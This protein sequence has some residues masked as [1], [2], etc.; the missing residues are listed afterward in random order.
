M[1][2]CIDCSKPLTGR[3][4]PPPVRC[5]SCA[6]KER[7]RRNGVEHYTRN[8]HRERVFIDTDVLARRVPRPWMR[9]EESAGLSR[10]S[11]SQIISRGTCYTS[12]L[13]KLEAALGCHYT[14]LVRP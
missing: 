3:S 10:G 7:I 11:L 5:K 14:E 1:R 12:T 2:T 6:Q 8:L 13:D 9:F 4:I